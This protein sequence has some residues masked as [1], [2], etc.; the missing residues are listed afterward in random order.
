MY[1]EITHIPF[2]ARWPGKAP[3]NT[4]SDELVSHVDLAGTLMD[5]FGFD[6]PKTVEGVSLLPLLKDPERGFPRMG[7]L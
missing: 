6:V 7:T 1:E 4:V 3:A 5:F 2:L